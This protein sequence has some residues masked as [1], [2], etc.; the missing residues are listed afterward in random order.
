MIGFLLFLNLSLT[1]QPL[2]TCALGILKWLFQFPQNDL[3]TLQGLYC[4]MLCIDCFFTRWQ[5]YCVSL[6]YFCVQFI[7]QHLV[8]S[9]CSANVSYSAGLRIFHCLFFQR[10]CPGFPCFGYF[11]LKIL[12][13][14]AIKHRKYVKINII[15]SFLMKLT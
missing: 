4:A 5:A 8:H 1:S 10:N 3:F 7:A 9:R 12:P 14:W 6:H 11:L 2:Q 15:V 13:N